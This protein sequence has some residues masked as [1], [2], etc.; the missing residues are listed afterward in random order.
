MRCQFDVTKF[1]IVH[2]SCA[3]YSIST[4][5]RFFRIHFATEPKLLVFTWYFL[6]IG[7][8]YTNRLGSITTTDTFLS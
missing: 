4:L 8:F 5:S 3:C 1:D 6:L 2:R 7:N